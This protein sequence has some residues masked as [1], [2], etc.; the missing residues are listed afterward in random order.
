MKTLALACLLTLCATATSF[1]QSQPNFGPNPPPYGDSFGQPP[2]GTHHP[3]QKRAYR[4]YAHSPYW[5]HR[6]PRHHCWW[7]HGHRHCRWY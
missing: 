6:Q 4:L 1:A 2:T 7:R 5:H 3:L